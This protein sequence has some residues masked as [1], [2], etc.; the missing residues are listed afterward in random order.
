MNIQWLS[1]QAMD[2]TPR[3]E[4]N[5]GEGVRFRIGFKDLR[6][7][8]HAYFSILIHNTVMHRVVTASSTHIGRPLQPG[9]SGV[10]E[11]V[12]PS[13]L[14]GDGLYNVMVDTGIYDFASGYFLSQDTISH[15]TYIG[16]SLNGYLKGTGLGEFQGAA[17]R[18]EWQVL[19]EGSPS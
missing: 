6:D 17:H 3:A 10:V 18:A 9:G 19:P 15:A 4:F 13:L 7:P 5:T 16:V 11:C 1:V 12:I 8:H 14:L 2:G